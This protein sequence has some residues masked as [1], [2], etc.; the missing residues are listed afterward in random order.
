MQ[1]VCVF[2]NLHKGPN[3]AGLDPATGELTRLYD[4]RRDRWR[5]HFAWLG[6]VLIGRTPIGRTTVHVLA[7]NDPAMVATREALIEEGRSPP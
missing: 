1:S 6:A 2:C 5:A 7:I 3:L 4:P